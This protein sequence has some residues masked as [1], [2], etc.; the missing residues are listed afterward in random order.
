MLPPG[1]AAGM[2][3]TAVLLGLLV[4][5]VVTLYER[6]TLPVRFVRVEGAFEHLEKKDV[7]RVLEPL[8]NVN[9]LSADIREM[10]RV[11]QSLPWVE[12]VSI[13]RVWP[14]TLVVRVDE[15]IAYARWGEEGL[16][17]R[18]GE[19]FVP[20]NPE[21]FDE[22]PLIRGPVGQEAYLMK[23]FQK[24]AAVMAKH[25]L[26]VEAL[27]VNGRRAWSARLA[28]GIKINMGRHEPLKAFARLLRVL[29]LLG[30]QHLAAMERIDLRYPNGF[31]VSWRSDI[32]RLL[33]GKIKN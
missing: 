31:A 26:S 30:K 5:G 9:Y 16:L 25:G 21:G 20:S 1:A 29:P 4:W 27:E 12:R 2:V 33:T 22:L 17:N 23:V 18:H 19:R 13:R 15:Q 14:D 32:D 7:Q 8:V 10:S 28:G 24:I 11:A 3:G 6:D